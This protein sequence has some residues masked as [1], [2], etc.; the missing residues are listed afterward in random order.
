MLK[1]SKTPF[2]PGPFLQLIHV[3]PISME[4]C[5]HGNIEHEL[6]IFRVGQKAAPF[7]NADNFVMVSGR[8]C[9]TSKVCNF[10][11]ETRLKFAE[12]RA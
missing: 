4:M 6:N 2:C 7:L 5:M 12:Q 11:L 8:T 1:D 10:C 9:H 3:K